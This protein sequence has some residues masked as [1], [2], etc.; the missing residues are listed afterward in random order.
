MN[1]HNVPRDHKVYF[2]SQS[3]TD[4]LFWLHDS[5]WRKS[6][7]WYF[8]KSFNIFL[9]ETIISASR[10]WRRVSTFSSSFGISLSFVK[11]FY[12]FKSN[13]TAALMF[14]RTGIFNRDSSNFR[15]WFFFFF[16]SSL[17][18]RGIIQKYKIMLRKWKDQWTI[19]N[20]KMC[21]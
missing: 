2:S 5:D 6:H 8:H 20:R 4:F 10:N 19:L 3:F 17:L 7:F 12:V 16:H 1:S 14:P 18:C 15:V 11:L 13:S 21:S 9:S